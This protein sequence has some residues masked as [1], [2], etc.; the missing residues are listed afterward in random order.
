MIP[1]VAGPALARQARASRPLL[2]V[3]FISGYADPEGITNDVRLSRLVRKPFRTSDLRQQI[4]KGSGRSPRTS[5]LRFSAY[6]I[7]LLAMAAWRIV[8]DLH[9][10]LL[11]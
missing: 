4:E 8:Q 10:T 7:R 5:G 11:A 2:P 6:S 1:G 3:I 9:R